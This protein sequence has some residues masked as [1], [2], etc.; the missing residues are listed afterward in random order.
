MNWYLPPPLGSRRPKLEARARS[1]AVPPLSSTSTESGSLQGP[2]AVVVLHWTTPGAAAAGTAARG[3]ASSDA[4]ATRR[5][6]R[7]MSSSLRGGPGASPGEP[8]QGPGM[9]ADWACVE[10]AVGQVKGRPPFDASAFYPY[11]GA[12]GSLDRAHAHP[13]RR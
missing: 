8:G 9:F 7:D 3:P 13:R 2:L 11:S 1:L 10:G 6:R 4:T 5:M 12:Y